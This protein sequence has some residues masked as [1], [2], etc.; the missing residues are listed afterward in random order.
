[1]RDRFIPSTRLSCFY[2]AYYAALGAFTPYWSLFLKHRNQS[3]TAISLLMALWYGTRIVAPGILSALAAQSATP[4]IWLRIGSV[5][6]FLSFFA[7]LLPMEFAG[8]FTAMVIFCFFYNAI[9]PQFEAITLSHLGLQVSHYGRIRVWGSV[10][11]ILIVAGFGL[12]LDYA[13]IAWLPWMMLPLFGIIAISSFYND[14]GPE[15]LLATG[16]SQFRQLLLRREVIVFFG[17]AFLMQISFGP[18]YTFFS[19]YL[20]QF[21]YRPVAL[22]AFWTAAV[23][24]EIVMFFF[25]N[26]ALQRLD[27]RRMI[28]LALLLAACRWIATALYPENRIVLGL[29]QLSHAITFA[30]FYAACMQLMSEYFPGRDNGHGQSVLYGF[31]S[32]LGGVLGALIAGQAWGI[33]NGRLAFLIAAGVCI[34]AAGLAWWGLSPIVRPIENS[35]TVPGVGSLSD[36]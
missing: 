12:A 33:G 35:T 20:D 25:S 34:A 23:L 7:F 24:V 26:R 22:G 28:L 18:Y 10:G 5:A 17:I 31:S 30:A 11:F 1:M 8:L 15:H 9:M 14:Y 16:T 2:F 4:I 32:G 6:A 3:T 36:S 13:S 21:G 29:A 19:L 27:A